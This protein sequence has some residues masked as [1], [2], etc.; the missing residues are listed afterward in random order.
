[1]PFLYKKGNH[2]HEGN[3]STRKRNVIFEAFKMKKKNEGEKWDF[4]H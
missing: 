2:A 3:G 1:M 4:G